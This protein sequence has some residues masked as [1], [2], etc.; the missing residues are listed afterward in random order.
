MKMPENLTI[1]ILIQGAL[2]LGALAL[3]GAVRWF[4]TRVPLPEKYAPLL[5]RQGACIY[6]CY[7][8]GVLRKGW[9]ISLPQRLSPSGSA[10]LLKKFTA[11]YFTKRGMAVF[12]TE[13]LS[14]EQN[15][16]PSLLIKKPN[17]IVIRDRRHAHRRMLRPPLPVGLVGDGCVYLRDVSESG[18]RVLLRQP[19][20]RGREIPLHFAFGVISAAVLECRLNVLEGF[21]YEARVI[22]AQPLSSLRVEELVKRWEKK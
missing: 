7:F 19:L 10:S 20:Q 15:P 9:M 5:L 6:E 22:F 2:F 18:A 1:V 16:V 12:E 14:V 17:W 8:I 4:R 13:I 3:A 11:S 21:P